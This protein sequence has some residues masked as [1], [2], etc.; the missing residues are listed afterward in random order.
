MSRAKLLLSPIMKTQNKRR[1]LL[2]I[3]KEQNTGCAVQTRDS[4]EVETSKTQIIMGVAACVWTWIQT[5][6]GRHWYMH[7]YPWVHA[8]CQTC[9]NMVKY[10]FEVWAWGFVSLPWRR[11][12]GV[13]C[14][15]TRQNLISLC[16]D[17]ANRLR[18]FSLLFVGTF[19]D[20]FFPSLFFIQKAAVTSPSV[21]SS[22]PLSLP[23]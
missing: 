19:A 13:S 16:V 21:F 4:P 3:K 22:V 2:Q 1:K 15:Q 18:L 7:M 6:W 10:T 9:E 23:V 5:V 11:D 8:C 12:F 14:R 20:V 17:V